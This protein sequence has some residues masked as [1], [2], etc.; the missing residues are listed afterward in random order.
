MRGY[1]GKTT[2]NNMTGEFSFSFGTDKNFGSGYDLAATKLY[3]AL[4]KP[5][6]VDLM[7]EITNY[8]RNFFLQDDKLEWKIAKR[9]KALL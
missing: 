9:K 6:E 4:G 5:N 1:D 2:K 8:F 7:E 3:E